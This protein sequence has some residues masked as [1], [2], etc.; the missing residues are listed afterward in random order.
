MV[1]ERLWS[2]E[3][4]NYLDGL[5]VA[6]EEGGVR[7]P[8]GE[9]IAVAL[10]GFA[11]AVVV[12]CVYRPPDLSADATAALTGAMGHAAQRAAQKGE[13][14]VLGGDV[15]AR[16]FTGGTGEGSW[17]RAP[18]PLQR[19]GGVSGRAALI[20]LA[21]DTDLAVVSGCMGRTAAESWTRIAPSGRDRAELDLVWGNVRARGAI[22]DVVVENGVCR[23]AL[24]RRGQGR[25]LSD[26]RMVWVTV[27]TMGA[28][29]D[30]EDMTGPARRRAVR[31]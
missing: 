30:V 26:H 8:Q 17:A 21:R 4:E 12:G 29:G 25:A 11:P 24:L 22:E 16:G 2:L 31:L 10:P 7:V 19:G 13:V 20:A 23:G 3:A 6:G 15:N 5:R 28:G 18:R 27:A 14:F 1:R 9:G